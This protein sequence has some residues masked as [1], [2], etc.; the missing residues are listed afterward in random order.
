MKRGGNDEA[1]GDSGKAKPAKKV[2]R[3]P[4]NV[5]AA[6]AERVARIPAPN[7]SEIYG[8]AAKQSAA[9]RNPVIV[10]PG[11]LGSRLVEKGTG[12]CIWGEFDTNFVDPLTPEGARLA[13][14]HISP[15]LALDEIRTP[16]EPDG[17][18]DKVRG[19]VLGLP[20]ELSAYREIILTLGAGGY[21]G[22]LLAANKA[23][24]YGINQLSTCFQF[25][26]DW[27]R[28]LVDNAAE[29]G[30]F[31]DAVLRYAKREAGCAHDVKVD[32]VCHS[33]GGMLA[34]YFVRYGGNRPPTPR[35]RIDM[36]E[37]LGADRV[38]QIVMIGTPNAGS[39]EAL[40]KLVIGLPSSAMTPPYT[41]QIL[42]T[43]P[44]IYQLL[45]RGR[46]G[47]AVDAKTGETI[48]DLLDIDL[49][50]RMGWGLA[51]PD[52]E[53]EL[54]KLV[55]ALPTASQRRRAALEHLAKCLEETRQ[56][57]NALDTPARVPS[58][59]SKYLFAGDAKPTARVA[60]VG[61]R[62]VD[63]IEYASGDGTVLRDSALMDERLGG[64]W[65]PRVQTPIDWAH[66]TFLHTDHMGLTRSPTFTDNLLYLLLE[67]P[68]TLCAL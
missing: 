44:S 16:V 68:R 30:R 52:A 34:R 5:V 8:R 14:L 53:A 21:T 55:P 31:I 48:K 47:C 64:Q 9:E 67:K 6:V 58:G 15:G 40:Q 45:P 1:S 57:Q 36:P 61:H 7:F 60:A 63:F 24:D 38:E 43:F 12:R 4:R 49:W 13:S 32:L 33:L 19:R 54:A 66:I 46:H 42:S 41:P 10:I 26:Y 27:R 25:P 62:Q 2:S 35:E 20:V 29:L 3:L 51:D 22:E 59:V 28:S 65:K 11:I 56:V 18:L 23:I 17:A 39:L 50:I 37:W